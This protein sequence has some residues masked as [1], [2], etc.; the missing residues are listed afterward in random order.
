M[1]RVRP[2]QRQQRAGLRQRKRGAD[3]EDPA[4]PAHLRRGPDGRIGRGREAP[5]LVGQAEIA[6]EAERA[7]RRGAPGRARQ[8][9]Q[10]AG[11]VVALGRRQQT[12]GLEPANREADHFAAANDVGIPDGREHEE[13]GAAGRRAAQRE[14]T[15]GFH[16][17]DR[18]AIFR[19]RAE[20]VAGRHA[21]AAG[22][23]LVGQHEVLGPVGHRREPALAVGAHDR[24]PGAAGLLVARPHFVGNP[25]DEA[26]GAEDPPLVDHALARDFVERRGRDLVGQ[27]VELADGIE[28]FHEQLHVAQNP[29]EELVGGLLEFAFDPRVFL[30]SLRARQSGRS[31]Q[32]QRQHQGGQRRGRS[33]RQPQEPL[34]L[35]RRYARI[36]L[37]RNRSLHPRGTPRD[38][39]TSRM[40][41]RHVS[42]SCLSGIPEPSARRCRLPHSRRVPRAWSLIAI[43][44]VMYCNT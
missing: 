20:I 13:P 9:R 15:V 26:V 21:E 10:Q 28:H 33:A 23:R 29:R 5:F 7:V 22:G 37:H 12:R 34:P 44:D 41:F 32:P 24:V 31:A 43:H 36:R 30:P 25:L 4:R 14:Y 11:R 1:R 16:R 39:K 35:R 40:A 19:A 3:G 27:A 38:Q 42:R 8:L 18:F 6:R 17:G 2:G